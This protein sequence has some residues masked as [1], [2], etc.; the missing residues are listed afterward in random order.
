MLTF[1]AGATSRGARVA[2]T[3][4]ETMSSARPWASFARVFAVAGATITSSAQ[5]ARA[6]W[7]IS[8]SWDG[9]KRS[10]RT[11]WPVSVCSTVG[12]T[13]PAA[14]RVVAQRT[15]CPDLRRARTSSGLLYEFHLRKAFA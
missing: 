8:P 12:E 13:N 1:I 15:A 2:R 3:T 5:S 4:A 6:M 10:L 7:S 9:S 11:V 14:S